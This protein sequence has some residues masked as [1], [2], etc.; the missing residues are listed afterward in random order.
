MRI[1]KKQRQHIEELNAVLNSLE[2]QLKKIKFFEDPKSYY[3]LK[4]KQN[5]IKTKLTMFKQS[6]RKKDF[7]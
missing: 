7:D 4:S 1:S 5:F 6:I 3:D 2:R